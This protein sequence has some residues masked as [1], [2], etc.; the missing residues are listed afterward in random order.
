VLLSSF[1]VAEG[2][3]ERERAHDDG[4]EADERDGDSRVKVV[5]ERG[6]ARRRRAR[7]IVRDR[8]LSG[9]SVPL[10]IALSF[11]SDFC[12]KLVPRQPSHAPSAKSNRKSKI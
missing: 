10:K 11:R 12:H 9:D 6:L 7:R 1:V 8:R 4:V 2:E 3:K 5:D